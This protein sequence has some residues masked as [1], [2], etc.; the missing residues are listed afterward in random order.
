M[1]NT[2]YTN[3]HQSQIHRLIPDLIRARQ[4]L[5]DLIWKDIRVRYRYAAMGFTFFGLSS[6]GMILDRAMRAATGSARE[7]AASARAEGI[8]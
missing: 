4:L 5:L 3:A 2:F 8:A 7:A 1:S 6:E